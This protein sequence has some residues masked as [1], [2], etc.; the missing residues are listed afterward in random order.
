MERM[1]Q[2]TSPT[3]SDLEDAA[4][5]YFAQYSEQDY[6]PRGYDPD[7]IGEMASYDAT[8]TEEGLA[9]VESELLSNDYGGSAYLA[10]RHMLAGMG[11]DIDLVS[12]ETR[13]MAMR[14]GARAVRELSL[15]RIHQLTNPDK[16]RPSYDRLFNL[17][18]DRQVLP[19]SGSIGLKSTTTISAASDTYRVRELSRNLSRSTVTETIRVLKWLAQVFGPDTELSRLTTDDLR[20]FREKLLR[21]DRHTQGRDVPFSQRQTGDPTRCISYTTAIKYWRFLGQFF[22]WAVE[23]KVINTNPAAIA[24]PPKPK[25]L[26]RQSPKPFTSDELKALFATPM[27]VG[28]KSPKRL[29]ETGDCLSRGGQWWSGVLFLHTGLRAGE[30]SQLMPSDFVF[31]APVPFL[32]VRETSDEGSE[33]SVKN[34]AS[35]REVPL[36]STLL[37]LGLE[38][39]VR[40]RS[41]Q[42]PG[43]RVFEVFRLGKHRKSE[44]ATRFWGDYLDRFGLRLAGRSTHVWRH[45]FI[46]SL[47]DRNVAVE[48]IA[49]L[50]GHAG[51]D[52]SDPFAHT[53][54]KAYGGGYS[55]ERK[56]IALEKLDFG[57][58]LPGVSDSEK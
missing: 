51:N 16:A 32:M 15:S 55:L 11:M 23:D 30:L 24:A 13:Q 49:A 39:F 57:F 31:N 4:R 53:Q 38:A 9:E 28:H 21:L 10:G 47:R 52:P 7:R 41:K 18:S 25:G 33:K 27:Y 40:S 29:T 12:A 37:A 46:R 56:Q 35:V 44:G 8:L 54:T 48:D 6:M 50:V 14:F 3:R 58:E 26:R 43:K 20:D 2:L 42:Q 36:H 1:M 17:E 19:K 34:E 45:T 22:R 5:A